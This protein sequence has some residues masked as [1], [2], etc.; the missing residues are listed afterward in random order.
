MDIEIK[1]LRKRFVSDYNLPIQVIQSPYFEARIELLETDFQAKT[2]YENLLELIKNDFNNNPKAFLEAYATVRNNIIIAIS[3]S[4]AFKSFNTDKTILKGFEPIIGKKSLYTQEQDGGLFISLDMKKANFQA[5]KY[6]DPNI[7]LNSQTYEELIAQFTNLDYIK[8]SKYTRQVI[9]GKLNPQRT[10]NVEQKITNELGKNLNKY[11]DLTN[12]ELF[13]INND[14]LLLKFCGSEEEFEKLT[15]VNT[16][17]YNGV[18]F[19]VSKFKLHHREFKL[20]TSDSSLNVYEKEDYL[21]GHKRHLFCVPA[22]YYPQVYKLLNGMEITP[23]DLIFYYEHEL[24]QFI[25]PLKL[26]K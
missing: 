24:C 9:F 6:Y 23:Y 3:H 16:I 7:V 18:L 26:I 2:K 20:A 8:E 25:N 19:K 13:S 17:N 4:D 10:I 11:I 12:L 22:T 14:E 21:N 5:L 15:M 1:Q